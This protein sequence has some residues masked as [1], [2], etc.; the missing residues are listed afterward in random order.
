M[1]SAMP[2]PI[3]ATIHTTALRHNLSQ[4]RQAAPDAQAWAVVKA[5][6]YGLGAD[7]VAPALQAAARGL[8]G[9]RLLESSAFPQRL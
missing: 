7:R 2:R 5:N 3:Q 6:A 9:V 4:A 8:Q 1:P